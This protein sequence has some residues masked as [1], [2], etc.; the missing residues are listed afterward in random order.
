MICHPVLNCYVHR[1]VC[2]S[3]FCSHQSL[4]RN[5]IVYK[6]IRQLSE[7]GTIPL[8]FKCFHIFHLLKLNLRPCFT[9]S[10]Y[11]CIIYYN[12]VFVKQFRK[13]YADLL[14]FCKMCAKIYL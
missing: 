6:A 14:T 4:Q 1:K 2:Q 11:I 8:A 12:F 7:F 5:I 3:I 13:I 10:H 9:L